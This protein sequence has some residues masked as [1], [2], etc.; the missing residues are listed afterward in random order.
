MAEK[1]GTRH[2]S[3][4]RSSRRHSRGFGF[5]GGG[6]EKK[7]HFNRA[8]QMK[9][10]ICSPRER[11]WSR[12]ADSTRPTT[13][14]ESKSGMSTQTGRWARGRTC[15]HITYTLTVVAVA[16]LRQ[17]QQYKLGR[18]PATPGRSWPELD[19]SRCSRWHRVAQ[20]T[21]HGRTG[22]AHILDT[23]RELSWRSQYESCWSIPRWPE[24]R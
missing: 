5:H 2:N 16:V 9:P 13:T 6:T 1:P 14:T 22:R 21:R 15:M 7:L 11:T 19:I 24:P 4:S 23:L 20:G 18:P 17:S 10:A 8:A 3:M 12:F